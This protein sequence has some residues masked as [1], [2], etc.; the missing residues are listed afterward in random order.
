MSSL[1][2][3]NSYFVPGLWIHTTLLD[4]FEVGF[5]GDFEGWLGDGFEGEGV[6]EVEFGDDDD[7]VDNLFNKE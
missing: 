1:L 5:E 3:W 2:V 7:M 4:G 6:F